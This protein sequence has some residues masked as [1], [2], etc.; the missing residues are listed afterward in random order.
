MSDVDLS[1]FCARPDQRSNL[2]KPFSRAGYTWATDGMAIMLRVPL[3]EDVPEI[4]NASH[5]ERV[6][7]EGT[8]PFVPVVPFDIPK[9]CSI[10]CE[11]CNGRVTKHSC[12]DCTCAC[13]ICGGDGQ[14]EELAAVSVGSSEISR[15]YAAAIMMLPAL[16]VEVPKEKSDRMHFRF[17]GGEGVLML[18]REHT[19][20]QSV[21]AD[22]LTGAAKP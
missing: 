6:W 20:S 2:S 3:R 16:A 12:P 21:V 1:K 17:D 4:A 18:L 15:R 11:V 19:E 13:G 14:I 10:Q 22:L 9:P 5:A 8:G 7:T